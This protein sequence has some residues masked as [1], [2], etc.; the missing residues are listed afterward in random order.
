MLSSSN[1]EAT[2]L[3]MITSILQ[4]KL[5]DCGKLKAF[6][7]GKLKVTVMLRFAFHWVKTLWEK[8]KMLV[9]SNFSYSRNV[10]PNAFSQG[11]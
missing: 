1:R 11:C 3:Q 9:T 6:A 5:F 4:G 2:D 7:D 10:F 8:D